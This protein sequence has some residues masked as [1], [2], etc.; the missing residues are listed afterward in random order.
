MESSSVN[1]KQ[2]SNK[3]KRKRDGR[4]EKRKWADNKSHVLI[5]LLEERTCLWDIYSNDYEKR[6]KKENVCTEL[7][8]YF[9]KTSVNAKSKI[10]TLRAQLRT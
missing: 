1:I 5:E 4:T 8:E 3:M 9:K 7:V 2:I 6:K 10:N